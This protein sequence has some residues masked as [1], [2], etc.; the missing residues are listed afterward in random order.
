MSEKKSV[1]E[2]IADELGVELHETEIQKHEPTEI[3]Q[4][5]EHADQDYRAVRGNLYDIISKGNDAIDGIL[6]VASEGDSPRAYEVAAQM[7]KTVAE[8]NKDLVDLHKRM[9]D[10]RKEETNINTT[11]NNAIYVG[12]T[13]DLQQLIDQSRSAAK[14]VTNEIVE[15]D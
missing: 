10:I 5:T 15:N 7:I 4:S 1:D 8:S 12:S 3:V 11:T 13:R 6:G 14:N 9:K 2:K